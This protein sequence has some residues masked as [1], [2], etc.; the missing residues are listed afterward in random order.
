[1]TLPLLPLRAAIRSACAADPALSAL[2]AGAPG[3]FDEAPRGAPPVYA[4]FGDAALRDLSTSSGTAHEQDVSILVYG[5][6]GSAATA[7]QAADRMAGLLDG[8]ALA[9]AGHH[10]VRLSLSGVDVGRDPETRLAR[11]TLRLA[12]ST[13]ALSG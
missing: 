3:P 12:A 4:V 6:A 13:E 11:V 2:T 1:M 9:L 5:R 8:A 7:L 10:L